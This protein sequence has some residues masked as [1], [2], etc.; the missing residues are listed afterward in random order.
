MVY[1]YIMYGLTDANYAGNTP[2]CLC[3]LFK[4]KQ[5]IPM[6]SPLRIAT[7]QSPLALWQAQEVQRLLAE[8]AVESTLVPMTTRGDQILDKPLAKIGGK[9]LFIKELQRG[10]LEDKAD[11]AV[12]S[13]K[14]VP[15]D[16]APGLHVEVILA[17]GNPHDALVSNQYSSLQQL[18]ANARVGTCSLRRRCQILERYP[19]FQ[20]LDLRGNVGTRLGKLDAGEFDAI[21]L[22]SAGLIRLGLQDRIAAEFDTDTMLPACAQGAIGI[23]CRTDDVD[24]NRILANL[25]DEKTAVQVRC[26]R[27]LNAALGGSCQTPIAGYTQLQG[28]QI[29]LQALVGEPDGSSVLRT[30]QSGHQQDARDIGTRAAQQ[31]IDAGAAKIIAS[32]Q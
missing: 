11:L 3:F 4:Q 29:E 22:A 24:V 25:H 16:N 31:L 5:V 21:I 28:D 17:R 13:M 7:R 1:L 32:L 2:R 19:A 6:A 9:G 15:A 20:I 18:P 14:D 27:A 8:H 26:E 12:H 23:E 10:I 30:T